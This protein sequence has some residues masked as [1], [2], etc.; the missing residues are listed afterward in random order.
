MPTRRLASVLFADIVGYTAMMQQNETEG[1]AK[2]QT[3]RHQVPQLVQDHRGEVI[4]IKGDG[5]LC[6]FNSA[7]EA[8][9]CAQ[10]IQQQ[11]GQDIPL[12]IGIHLGDVM[13]H[14]DHIMGDVV[15]I[16]S[17]IESMGVAG[18]V[19]LSSS[20]RQQI[21]NK[22]EFEL[23]S[24]GKFAFKNVAEPMTVYA[25]GNGGFTV[26]RPEDM[27]GK[28]KRENLSAK[29]F[30][31]MASIGFMAMFVGAILLWQF[32]GKWQGNEN[33]LRKD[34]REAKVAVSVFENFTGEENLDALGYMASEWVSS[35]LR[36][37]KVRTVSPE[38]VRQNMETIG[39]LPGNPENRASFNEITGAEYVVT[40]S[41]F[42]KK[43]SVLLN[44]RLSSTISGENITT[45]DDLRGHR[46]EKEA[47]IQEAI[48]YLMGYWAARKDG[49]ERKI[50][51]PKYEAYKAYRECSGIDANCFMKA[52]ALDSSFLS[53]RVGLI[54]AAAYAG[55]DSICFSNISIVEQNLDKATIHE[56]LKFESFQNLFTQD[57][58]AAVQAAK[59]VHLLD[60]NDPI[61]IHNYASSLLYL[62][63]EPHRTVETYLEIF[64]KLTL[65]QEQ[66]LSWTYYHYI[67]AL[68]RT[69]AYQKAS[70]FY[71]GLSERIKINL[72]DRPARYAVIALIYQNRI[73]EAFGIIEERGG[74]KEEYLQAA[75][76]YNYI[77]PERH[78]PFQASLAEQIDQFED[79]LAL[80]WEGIRQF[81][82]KTKATV[83]YVLGD[84]EKA[85][86]ALLNMKKTNTFRRT[87]PY[88]SFPE[89]LY[90]EKLWHTA[91][92]GCVYAQLGESEN[93]ENQIDQ[94]EN[95]GKLYPSTI[96][97]FH[98]G[99]SPY[100]MARV[101]AEL[102]EKELA[103]K[104][105]QQSADQGRPFAYMSFTADMYLVKLKGYPPFE[106]LIRPK[107]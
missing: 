77:F 32:G 13:Q 60:K 73:E 20:I 16:A 67:D 38:M 76:I 27:K 83:Y 29:S 39:I 87:A 34:I 46:N 71:L 65:Y 61:Q 95:W 107:G 47:L 23:V 57:Y 88:S 48:D 12:R 44:T 25:L 18:A 63:N 43:D 2:A 22:P 31:R 79:H 59:E 33:L 72:W 101:Y 98:R 93:A 10:Q 103:V 5:A 9:A 19:L 17:R 104:Y 40:G 15:N 35:G 55:R 80:D 4:E 78:N 21:K 28:G 45:F 26:P 96:A 90:W 41:Y 84:F 51:P 53:A 8:T 3:F 97:M 54:G 69:G 50:T 37:L 52:L 86:V 62:L 24:M 1:M 82:W 36:E 105:L 91:M 64:N 85:K 56:R 89:N 100:Y 70:D 74:K 6:L 42:L 75:F 81:D 58:R 102:G 11:L 68:N 30:V 66:L 14:S 92:L 106:E 7:A 49:K 99:I 94:L